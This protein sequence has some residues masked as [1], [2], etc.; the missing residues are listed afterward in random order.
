LPQR[1]DPNEVLAIEL[2]LA[3]RAKNRKRVLLAAPIVN[4]PVLLAEWKLQ[5][6]TGQRLVYS[7]G[8]LAPKD[9]T[10]V[11]GF[12]QLWRTLSANR[13]STA[14]GLVFGALI[15][16]VAGVIMWR[17]AAGNGT[18]RFSARYITG[19]ALGVVALVL[20]F[21]ALL[22]LGDLTERQRNPVQQE[23]T[24]LAPV[25]QA[26]SALTLEVSNVSSRPSAARAI[27]YAW[28]AV[29]AL[30]RSFTRSLAG[31]DSRAVSS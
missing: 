12:G 29:L 6:D 25:Q 7:K 30:F 20:A 9:V 3:A 1:A 17:W 5:A 11:S 22:A 10:E 4:A 26:G 23:L 31:L 15:M 16:T 28:P 19:T 8:S 21:G 2:K 24:F 13:S 14:W 18:Q 27:G